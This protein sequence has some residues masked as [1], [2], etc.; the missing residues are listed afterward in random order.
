VQ[1]DSSPEFCPAANMGQ[2]VIL[3]L[4]GLRAEGWLHA[5]RAQGHEVLHWPATEIAVAGGLSPQRLWER[6]AASDWVVLP[7]PSAVILVMQ[8]LAQV[9]LSWPRGCGLG[10][11]GPGSH[12][13]LVDW[14]ARVPGLNQAAV[15]VPETE[16]FDAHGLLRQPVF[17][18]PAGLK[19]LVLHRPDGQTRW[20]KALLGAGACLEVHAFYCQRAL[21]W[22]D[23]AHPW[24]ARRRTAQQRLVLSIASRGA[25]RQIKQAT[26][27]HGQFDW[28]ADQVVFTH[29]P[30]IANELQML[31]FSR[32]RQHAPGVQA[33][34]DALRALESGQTGR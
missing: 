4:P 25:A 20:L 3:T 8:A 9:G 33:L 14:F 21:E 18:S 34:V 23:S 10:L 17:V 29:H 2:T 12:Q 16:P 5:L 28:L 1:P 24:L 27:R 13:V 6:I 15:A 30:A 11:V 26:L 22:P 32:V 31:G 7:S 19:V